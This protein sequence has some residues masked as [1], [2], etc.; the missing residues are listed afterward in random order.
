MSQYVYAT[1]PQWQKSLEEM[2]EAD[3]A[4]LDKMTDQQ[5]IIRYA[6]VAGLAADGGAF[7]SDRGTGAAMPRR[8][9]GS[10]ASCST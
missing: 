2:S 4:A 3:K 7:R 9:E 5:R 10:Q 6:E 1:Q 8:S